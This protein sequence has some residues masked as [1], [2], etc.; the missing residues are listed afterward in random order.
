MVRQIKTFLSPVSSSALYSIT[1][2]SLSL[3]A[4]CKQSTHVDANTTTHGHLIGTK[5]KQA[6]GDL[7]TGV[8]A[9]EKKFYPNGQLSWHAHRNASGM[10]H[11]R[12][13][14]YYV[15]GKLFEDSYWDQGV[16]VHGKYYQ[17]DGTV[18]NEII[19]GS[20]HRRLLWGGSEAGSEEYRNG[21]CIGGS[22]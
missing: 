15:S 2:I 22:G 19:D 1:L 12:V 3:A 16:V 14:A 4:C 5:S 6:S 17:E 18:I 20:G 11:G 8:L 9:E 7:R 13:L 21:Y 10:L